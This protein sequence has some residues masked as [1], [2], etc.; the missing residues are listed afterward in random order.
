MDAL[1]RQHL[2]ERR[3]GILPH[4]D[5]ERVDRK[6]VDGDTRID[7]PPHVALEK[8]GDTRGIFAREDGQFHRTTR[9]KLGAGRE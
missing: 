2:I 3:V 6:D 4:C 1:A 5:V 9:G 7:Q 8:R